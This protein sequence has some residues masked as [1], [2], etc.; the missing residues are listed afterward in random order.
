MTRTRIQ[1]VGQAGIQA[2]WQGTR[3]LVTVGIVLLLL[4]NLLGGLGNATG[5][6]LVLR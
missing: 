3:V 5:V 2:I 6:H 1:A 4:D